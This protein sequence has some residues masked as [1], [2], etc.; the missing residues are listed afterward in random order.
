M[1]VI[2]IEC[3]VLTDNG[4]DGDSTTLTPTECVRFVHILSERL[5]ATAS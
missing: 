2:V 3:T 5:D 1:V 4:D